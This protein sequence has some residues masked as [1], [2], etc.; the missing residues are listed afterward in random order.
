MLNF[1]VQ[2]FSNVSLTCILDQNKPFVHLSSS[3]LYETDFKF[4]NIICPSCLCRIGSYTQFT[5]K[6]S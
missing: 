4:G 2:Y 3:V 1:S 6:F 5:V